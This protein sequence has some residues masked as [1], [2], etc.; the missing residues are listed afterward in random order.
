MGK[1]HGRGLYVSL[2]GEV[3]S[4]Y[5]NSF[6]PNRGADEHD[7]TTYGA[8]HHDFEGGLL[9]GSA[10][11]G[12]FYDSAAGG[13]AAVIEPLLGTKVT[14]VWRP[15]GTGTGKPEKSATVL[16]KSFNTSIPVA[17]MITFTCEVTFCSEP[18]T[19]TQA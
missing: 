7:T 18:T 1:V 10:T 11:I 3:I 2:D 9:N 13:P 17:D 15:E 12:G 5:C 4:P 14:C 6:V 16:V 19:T 8:E